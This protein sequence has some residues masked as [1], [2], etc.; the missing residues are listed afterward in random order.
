SIIE[1]HRDLDSVPLN[2]TAQQRW[3]RDLGPKSW[4]RG[5]HAGALGRSR[6]ARLKSRS[7]ECRPPLRPPS[8]AFFSFRFLPVVSRRSRVRCSLARVECSS[9]SIPHFHQNYAC[10]GGAD[11]VVALDQRGFSPGME[12]RLPCR[13]IAVGNAAAVGESY[14]PLCRSG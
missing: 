13:T 5:E 7:R 3:P 1:L 2:A 9:C 8:A 10:R 14:G 11:P 4:L 12:A 6:S